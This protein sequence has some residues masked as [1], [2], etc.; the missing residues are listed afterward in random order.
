M[1]WAVWDRWEPANPFLS[2]Y[3][4]RATNIS[5]NGTGTNY[6]NTAAFDYFDDTA[7]A[8][9]YLYF[10]A[11]RQYWGIQLEVGTAFSATSVEFIWEYKTGSGTWATLPVSNPNALL[12]TGTQTVLFSPPDDDWY[13]DRENGV[14]IRCRIVSVSGLTEGGANATNVVEW[15]FKAL[16]F[17]GTDTSL[18][19]AVTADLAGSYTLLEATTPAASLTPMRMPVR[20]LRT[21]SKLDV[22]LSGSTAGAGDTVTLTGL[23]VA[24]D[25]FTETIDVSSGDGT[26]TTTRSYMDCTGVACSGWSD[27]TIT[28][29]QNRWGLIHENYVDSFL[30][31]CCMVF[32]DDSTTTSMTLKN[33]AL[34]FVYNA[35]WYVMGGA[36]LTMGQL[37]N[38]GTAHEMGVYGCTIVEQNAELGISYYWNRFGGGGKSV[39]TPANAAAIA[40]YGTR[41]FVRNYGYNSRRI[42]LLCTSGTCTLTDCDIRSNSTGDNNELAYFDS[43][44]LTFTRVRV[45]A[46][47]IVGGNSGTITFNDTRL[48]A[49]INKFEGSQKRIFTGVD[50]VS[51]TCWMYNPSGELDFVNGTLDEGNLSIGYSGMTKTDDCIFL[52][53]TFDLTVIDAAGTAISGASVTIADAA[54][55]MVYFGT[56]DASGQ[57]PQQTLNRK[58]ADHAASAAS[59]TW[60]TLTPHVVT[61]TKTGYGDYVMHL[62]M[63]VERNEVAVMQT[64]AVIVV[65]D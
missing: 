55:T 28:L 33:L 65:E 37:N 61:I 6:W 30:I 19:A 8:G 5:R 35:F 38:S 21:V 57:I 44:T 42:T 26:Y 40:L 36:T 31:G 24:G 60:T 50:A 47:V 10:A 46:M 18:D 52:Q 17:T 34:T 25:A 43:V 22:V 45:D 32:G 53:Y 12:S 48:C 1:T 59:F 7:V 56:T 41:W 4:G 11:T 62:T 3:D 54:G 29:N 9:D 27:G 51:F 13:G 58:R 64:G 20:A 15:L 2:T 14:P 23:D 39:Y 49:N 63:D 16:Q